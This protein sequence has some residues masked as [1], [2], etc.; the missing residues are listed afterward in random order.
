ML[1]VVLVVV[2]VVSAIGMVVF[3]LLH[4]GKGGG[5]SDLMGGS[6]LS[7]AASSSVAERNLD[8]IT[9][10]LALA[11]ALSSIALGLRL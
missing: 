9:I 3:V 2:Q 11:F 8:H 7:S 6:S 10:V 5:L 4:S 1:T